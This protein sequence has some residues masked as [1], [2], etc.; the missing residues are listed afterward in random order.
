MVGCFFLFLLPIPNKQQY[1][2][3]NQH[4]NVSVW[5]ICFFCLVCREVLV[6]QWVG[7]SVGR[8]VSQSVGWFDLDGCR[9]HFFSL[10]Q[11]QHLSLSLSLSVSV[12]FSLFVCDCLPTLFLSVCDANENSYIASFSSSKL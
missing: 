8:L 4:I 3:K 2:N 1:I 12:S 6:D 5:C 9:R 11:H 10:C 7:R